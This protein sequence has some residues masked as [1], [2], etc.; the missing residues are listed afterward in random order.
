MNPIQRAV[1]IVGSQTELAKRL[2]KYNKKG[3]LTSQAVNFWCSKNKVPAEYVLPIERE[4][5]RK[6]TRHELRP[7]LY[8]IENAPKKIKAHRSAAVQHA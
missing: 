4:T 1:S 2:G 3:K 8:P 5:G 6:V 7:D